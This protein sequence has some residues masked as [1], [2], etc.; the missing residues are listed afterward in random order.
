MCQPSDDEDFGSSVAEALGCGI[1]AIVGA[2]NGTGDYI[3]KR[4][5]RLADDNPQTM[6]A[7]IVAMADAK[8]RGELVDPMPSRHIAERWFD[9]DKVTDQL[10]AVLRIANNGVQ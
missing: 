9:P 8:K 6:A 7:A 4:S 5:I 3:C 1:P 10:E 2:T